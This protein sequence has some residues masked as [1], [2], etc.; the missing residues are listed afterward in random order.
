MTAAERR[1]GAPAT[2]AAGTCGAPAVKPARHRAMAIGALVLSA[3]CWGMA[4]V[5][6][7]G[8]LERVPPFT[9]L[10]LQL[11]ASSAFLW[12]AVAVTRTPVRLG[13]HGRAILASGLLE[14]GLAYAVALPGLALTRASDASIISAAEPAFICALIWMATRTRPRTGV[15]LALGLA[16]VGVLLVIVAP[17][18]VLAA[19]HRGLGN[20]LVLAGTAI[21]ALYVVVSGRLVGMLAPLPLAALQQSAGLGSAV[22]LLCVGV[23]TGAEALPAALPPPVLALAALSGV[24]QYAL[25]VWFYLVGLKRIPAET[26]GL[27]LALIPVFGI[28]GA[29]LFLGEAPNARQLAGAFLVAAA[30][31]GIARLQS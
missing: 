10:A 24:V 15:L 14:P 8:A 11:A 27:F 2:G 18:P 19:A 12:T 26:A 6:S 3:A 30:V 4:T 1:P 28:V 5:M 21:A 22:G 31:A 20:L 23:A 25:A 17:S 9:L 16:T 7:K 13:P 29:A